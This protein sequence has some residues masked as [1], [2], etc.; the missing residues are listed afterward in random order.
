VPK[1]EADKKGARESNHSVLG[2]MEAHMSLMI[3][4]GEVGVIGTAD[5]ATMG[6]Y[7]AK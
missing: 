6:Y 4:E 3:C 5:K 7:V 1:T 2:A